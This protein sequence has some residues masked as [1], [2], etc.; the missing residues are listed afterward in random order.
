MRLVSKGKRPPKPRDSNA[1]GMTPL[2]WEIAEKCW[3]K[4]AKL[5][6][7]V[8]AVLRRLE[9]MEAETGVCTPEVPVATRV[10]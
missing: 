4:K 6:P 8:K 1:P 10:G 3:H 5:R 2:V 9:N 7:D